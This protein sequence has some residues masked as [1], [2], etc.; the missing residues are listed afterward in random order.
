MSAFIVDDGVIDVIITYGWPDIKNRFGQQANAGQILVN[1]N[2]RSVNARYNRHDTPHKYVYQ[3]RLMDKLAVLRACQLYD[4][5]AC[6]TKDYYLSEAAHLIRSVQYRAIS[7]FDGYSRID[8]ARF[9]R[10]YKP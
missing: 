4:Y 2:Y 3:I 7:S 8:A 10:D 5:Q 1:E 6:E 9:C